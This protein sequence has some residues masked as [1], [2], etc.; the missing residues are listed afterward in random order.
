MMRLLM[1]LAVIAGAAAAR[2]P[3]LGG[4]CEGCEAVFE[5]R[6]AQP[7]SSARIAPPGEPGAPLLLEGRVTT[8]A[9]APAAGIIV[10]AYHT[11]HSGVYPPAP[12]LTGA[13][14]RHGRLR[15][16]A[17]TDA[18][19]RYRFTTI[20]PGAYPG[21]NIPAHVHLHVLEPGRGT[22][23]IDDVHFADDPLLTPGQ[24][25]QLPGRGGSGIAQPA[26]GP[27]GLWRVSR[28]IVL[29]LNIPG[30]PR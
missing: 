4:P 11:D 5:G 24:R 26:R 12:G 16:W 1:L 20:R 9:G 25:R 30:Y 23:Y 15:A 28:D 17:V 8:L 19:G 10:Y 13:A 21:E 7:G 27:D 18:Q 6:P 29:G 3:V 14:R 2:E 22:Y